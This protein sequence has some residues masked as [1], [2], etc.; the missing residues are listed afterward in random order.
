MKH[1]T[2]SLCWMLA[3]SGAV[4]PLARPAAAQSAVT[5]GAGGRLSVVELRDTSLADALEMIFK[6]AGNP[7][8]IIDDSAQYVPIPS[9]TLN[10]IAWDA[11]V[12]NL[13]NLNNFKVSRNESGAWLVEP[14]AP[15]MLDG[16]MTGEDGMPFGPLG[17]G[18]MMPGSPLGSGGSMMPSNPFGSR[19]MSP[20]GFAR[21]SIRTF[22]NS[23]TRPNTGAGRGGNASN[24]NE[25]KDYRVIVVR[26]IYAGGL[27]RLFANA[28]VIDTE[29]FVSP[30][31]S[32]G[33]GGSGSR[34]GRGG[35]GMG[36]GGGRGGRASGIGGGLGGGIG[37]NVGG[38]GGVS[39]LGGGGGFGGGGIGGGG[40]G[41]GGGFGF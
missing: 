16:Q 30:A 3:L 4:L 31:A 20:G 39:G 24:P 21:P 18:S 12:R 26:H 8:H 41:F 6:S 35:G 37:G 7:S 11:A 25:G 9:V 29:S 10:N 2:S 28:T 5:T 40:G 1:K 34:S 17:S 15:L 32:G 36:G 33:N 13:A 19:P 22:A 23:Q 27:A 14:R 38:G